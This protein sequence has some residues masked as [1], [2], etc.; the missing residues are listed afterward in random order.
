MTREEYVAVC[1]NCELRKIDAQKGL[2]CS[3]TGGRVDF[4]DTC[5]NYEEDVNEISRLQ[6]EAQEHQASLKVS[7]W[8]AFFLWVGVGLGALVSMI[9]NFNILVDSELPILYNLLVVSNVACLVTIAI[10]TIIAFYKRKN[11]AVSLALT[12]IAMITISGVLS[13]VINVIADDY[14]NIIPAIRSLVW[15]GIWCTYI[16]VSSQVSELI[17][18]ATRRWNKLEKLLLGLYILFD[19]LI[20]I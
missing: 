20:V 12:Y 8:L 19:I 3:L 6:K 2:V 15:A 13:L 18:K 17:P 4:T 1:Q 10:L 5:V 9:Q 14:A 16:F 7:G 11:N